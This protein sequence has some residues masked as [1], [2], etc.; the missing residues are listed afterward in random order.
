MR[1]S[2][3]VLAI[4]MQKWKAKVDRERSSQGFG[5]DFLSCLVSLKKKRWWWR[6]SCKECHNNSLLSGF[7]MT[8][9]LWNYEE[10]QPWLILDLLQRIW[11]QL[12]CRALSWPVSDHDHKWLATQILCRIGLRS[13]VPGWPL[14][15][16]VF[17]VKTSS[18]FSNEIS[19]FGLPCTLSWVIGDWVGQRPEAMSH[20]A[21]GHLPLTQGQRPKAINQASGP[22][23]NDNRSPE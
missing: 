3:S 6:H 18:S 23:P 17:I 5:K 16:H 21:A 9:F 19:G 20:C 15:I 14:D 7:A 4:Q 2:R 11:C 13:R 12:T 8:H 22:D 1:K 10:H